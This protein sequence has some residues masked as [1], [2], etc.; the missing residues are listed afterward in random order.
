M[1]CFHSW[2]YE[3][4]YAHFDYAVGYRNRWVTVAF[5]CFKCH[6][7]KKVAV[8]FPPSRS[9]KQSKK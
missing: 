2:G 7:I 1:T 3:R 9:K 6:V 4:T 5:I 8:K